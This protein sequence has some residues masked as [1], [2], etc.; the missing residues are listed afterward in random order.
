MAVKAETVPSSLGAGN[1]KQALPS[2]SAED[3]AR[4]RETFSRLDLGAQER[5]EVFDGLIRLGFA[6]EESK[7]PDFLTQ[8]KTIKAVSDFQ[9][10]I[11]ARVTGFLNKTQIKILRLVAGAPLPLTEKTAESAGAEPA[12]KAFENLDLSFGEQQ[13]AYRGLF[14]LGFATEKTANPDFQNNT[15]TQGAVSRYQASKGAMDTGFLTRSQVLELREQAG[16]PF[17]WEKSTR[18]T[19]ALQNYE[20]LSMNSWMKSKFSE[21][22]L[23]SIY[24]ALFNKGFLTDDRISTDFGSLRTRSAVRQYQRSI[25]EPPTGILT[26]KQA[27]TLLAAPGEP[28]PWEVTQSELESGVDSRAQRE[29]MARRNWRQLGVSEDDRKRIFRALFHQGHARSPEMVLDDTKLWYVVRGFQRD[30]GFA[31]TGF[32]TREQVDLLLEADAPKLPSELQEDVF[33]KYGREPVVGYFKQLGA[34]EFSGKYSLKV[35]VSRMQQKLSLPVTGFVTDEL[36]E[37]SKS[38]SI[39]MNYGE[40][41]PLFKSQQSREQA[42]HKDWRRWKTEEGEYCEIGSTAVHVEGFS[43][44]GKVAAISFY[45][46]SDWHK[47]TINMELRLENWDKETLA[48]VKIGKSEFFLA[49]DGT[50]NVLVSRHGMKLKSERR[51]YGELIKTMLRANGFEI[52]YKS[53][54]GNNVVASFSALGLTRQLRAIQK[55]C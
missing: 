52:T 27:L 1:A 11:D 24:R 50:V 35:V 46:R 14:E 5:Q 33:A 22:E 51:V 4:A 6:Q 17:A 16:L 43:G 36:I 19:Y 23:N 39:K 45:R 29:L 18:R 12:K 32:L 37:A 47:S 2:A 41:T 30:N 48:K 25:S 54:F 15:E 10:A 53:V 40:M 21:K 44:S 8:F 7:E 38:I 20:V 3:V 28:T 34:Q 31:V 49:W 9:K 55:N 26:E 42:R 13:E